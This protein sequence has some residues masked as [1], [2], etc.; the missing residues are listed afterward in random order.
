MINPQSCPIV[1]FFT[2]TM[3]V[4]RS[5]STSAIAQTS[6]GPRAMSAMPRPAAFAAPASGE[7]DARSLHAACFAVACSS[8]VARATEL[9]QATAKQ[10]AWRERASPSPEAG[11]AKAAGR[12]IALIARGPTLVC[13]IAEVEVERATGIVAVKKMTMGHDCGLIINPDGLKF[14]IEA[15]VM[16]GVSRALIEE[17]KWD[18]TGIKTVDWRTYPVITFARVP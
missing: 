5:T 16:Q 13:A 7:G 17:V 18:A 9:L 1:I 4:A 14:Q 12:G 15:N 6:V 2:A 3:P 11:A 10:A 8:S